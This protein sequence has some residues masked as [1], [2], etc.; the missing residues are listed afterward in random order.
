LPFRIFNNDNELKF[1]ETVL[2]R[3]GLLK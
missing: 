1:M 3:K 2:K